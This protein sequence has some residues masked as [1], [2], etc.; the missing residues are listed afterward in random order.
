MLPKQLKV[1]KSSYSIIGYHDG[2]ALA[3]FK[4]TALCL[5]QNFKFFIVYTY[6]VDYIVKRLML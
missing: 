5:W 2:P 6:L 4:M 3:N 1:L